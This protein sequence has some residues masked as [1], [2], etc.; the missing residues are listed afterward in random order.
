VNYINACRDPITVSGVRLGPGTTDIEFALTGAPAPLPLTLQPG[1]AFTARVEY[2]AQVTGM[3]MSPLFVDSSELPEPLL[4]PL[5]GESSSRVDKTDTFIQQDGSKVDVLFVVDNTASMVE[6]Q[7][8]FI[9]ALPAFVSTALEKKVD[10]HVAVTTTG[11]QPESS[12]CPGGAAGGEAG[13][14]FP[15]D[16]SRERILTNRTADLASKL[17]GN[18]QVGLCTSVEQGFE[19]V[20]RALSE[21]LVDGGDDPRTPLPN[22]GNRGFLRDEAALVVVFVGDEDD[23]SPDSVA[24]YVRFFQSKKGEFQPQRMT[25]YAIAPTDAS[26]STAGGVGTRYAEAATRTGGEVVS[27]CAPDYAPLMRNVANKAFSPQDR[28]P[29]SEPPIPG[30]VAVQVN[31]APATGWSYDGASNSV[32]FSPG[33]APGAKVEISYRRACQ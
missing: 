2:F 23:H 19:A 20:R 13:R 8:R 15:V 33:P 16:N 27:V 21:P 1:D 18:A 30:S 26:C 17:Q 6:E 12:T 3:N 7:P 10:L 14:F 5:L 31:G 28:F 9:N 25:I 11:I 32:V 4:V 22:D 29:L 24:T